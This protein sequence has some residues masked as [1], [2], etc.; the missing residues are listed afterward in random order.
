VEENYSLYTYYLLRGLEGKEREVFD[1]H[2]NITIDTLSSYVDKKTRK[3]KQR[4]IRKIESSGDMIVVER[5]IFSQLKKHPGDRTETVPLKLEDKM[6]FTDEFIF[7]SSSVEEVQNLIRGG[8]VASTHPAK[9]HAFS[10]FVENVFG[11]VVDVIPGIEKKVGKMK[12]YLVGIG[13]EENVD[14]DLKVKVL[15]LGYIKEMER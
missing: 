12:R 10:R 9:L 3:L 5:A 13:K 11:T 2:G 14:G 6:Q 7:K 1:R 4:P 15:C 8:N